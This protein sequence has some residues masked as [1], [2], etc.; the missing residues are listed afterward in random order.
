MRPY[1]L[2]VRWAAMSSCAVVG[3]EGRSAPA[4]HD[5]RVD[6]N[7]SKRQHSVSV[8]FSELCEGDSPDELIGRADRDCWPA[9]LTG[10]RQ[11]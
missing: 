1:D 8:G 11:D 2:L 7:G 4:L 6:L 3:V 9:G 10:P 5:L